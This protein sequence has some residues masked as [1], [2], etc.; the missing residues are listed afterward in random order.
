MFY[1]N[2]KLIFIIFDNL[3]EFCDFS[4]SLIDLFFKIFTICG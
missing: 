1:K 4:I 3:L 2:L